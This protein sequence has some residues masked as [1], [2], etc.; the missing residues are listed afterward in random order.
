M[1]KFLSLVCGFLRLLMPFLFN[2]DAH[3]SLPDFL[4]AGCWAKFAPTKL[5]K[6]T[7]GSMTKIKFFAFVR[8]PTSIGILIGPAQMGNGFRAG[9][10]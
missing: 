5:S 8:L 1:W 6:G 3:R 10:L 2:R 7:V 4:K 9:R